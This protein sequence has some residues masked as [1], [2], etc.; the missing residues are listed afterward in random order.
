MLWNAFQGRWG[1]AACA[2]IAG[3]CT[4]TDGIASPARQERYTTPV[5]TI[6][7]PPDELEDYREAYDGPQLADSPRWPPKGWPPAEGTPAPATPALPG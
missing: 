6:P 4:Q 3:A 1:A 5:D 7:G 2:P